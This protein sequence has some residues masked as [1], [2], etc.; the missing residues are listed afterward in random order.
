MEGA[1]LPEFVDLGGRRVGGGVVAVEPVSAVGVSCGDEA[2]GVIDAGLVVAINEYERLG[3][4]NKEPFGAHPL[5]ARVGAVIGLLA[6][7]Q[8]RE[9]VIGGNVVIPPWA[10]EP[11]VVTQRPFVVS[12]SIKRN[13]GTVEDMATI[14]TGIQVRG[15]ATG[16]STMRAKIERKRIQESTRVSAFG[17]G[18]TRVHEHKPLVVISP[19]RGDGHPLLMK[20]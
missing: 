7:A 1:V 11:S 10:V 2:E 9:H 8:A 17:I 6:I 15:Q 14:T 12:T 13:G 20:L 16:I 19:I 3:G 4:A 5:I 18:Y